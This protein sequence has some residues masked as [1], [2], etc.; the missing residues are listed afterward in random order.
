MNIMGPNTRHE[1]RKT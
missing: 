1:P